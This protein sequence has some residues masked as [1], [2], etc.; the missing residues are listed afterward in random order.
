ML[1]SV[2]NPFSNFYFETIWRVCFIEY[3]L[4]V[5]H[6]YNVHVVYYDRYYP[7]VDLSQTLFQ[8]Q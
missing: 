4:K 2:Q 7:R 6:K 5:S 8:L 3:K 1:Q